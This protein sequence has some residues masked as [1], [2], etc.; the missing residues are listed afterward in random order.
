[1]ADGTPV[2]QQ[3]ATRGAQST[4]DPSPTL[5]AFVP[6]K[7]MLAGGSRRRNGAGTPKALAKKHA[8]V[9]YARVGDIIEAIS[10]ALKRTISEAHEGKSASWRKKI[11][12]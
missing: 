9:I 7:V 8:P 4:G 12:E 11:R 6:P 3:L 5:V 2:K 10:R 1:M